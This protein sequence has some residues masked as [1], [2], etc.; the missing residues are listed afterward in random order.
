ME[1]ELK[2]TRRPRSNEIETLNK[3]T[4]KTETNRNRGAEKPQ[5]VNQNLQ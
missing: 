2:E 3:E 5:R 4:F 1:Q